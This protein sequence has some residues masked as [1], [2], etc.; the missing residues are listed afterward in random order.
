MSADIQY[1]SSFTIPAAILGLSL[2]L[3][4]AVGGWYVYKVKAAANTISVTGS[5]QKT[6]TSDVAKW[7]VSLSRSTG[8]DNVKD[9]YAQLKGDLALLN[10]YLKKN[11]IDPKAVTVGTVSVD[12]TYSNNGGAD[13][14]VGYTVHQDVTVE[15]GDVQKIT[16][17]AQNAGS[18]LAQGAL[19]TTTSLEYYYSKLP[20]AKLEMLAEATKNAQ[21]RARKIAESAGAGLG[22]LKDASMGVMQITAVN[23]TDVSDYGSYDTTSVDKQITAIVR[24]S[25]GVR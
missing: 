8:T 13:G 9:G 15:T 24:A 25:F 1:R 11:G 14:P 2:L 20:E 3:S 22:A 4:T 10:A 18:L 7:H 12:P 17:T 21:E 6:I 16:A 23:S 19:L 5:A